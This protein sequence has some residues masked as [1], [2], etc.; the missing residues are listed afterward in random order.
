[1]RKSLV[2]SSKLLFNPAAHNPWRGIVEYYD[3]DGGWLANLFF[4]STSLQ[5][6]EGATREEAEKRLNERIAY[7]EANRWA[8]V[9]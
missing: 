7:I 2:Q 9:K 1:M 3:E 5:H 4:R 6:V 8:E